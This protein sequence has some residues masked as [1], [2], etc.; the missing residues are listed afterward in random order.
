MALKNKDFIEIEYTGKVKD[1][2]I[3]FDTTN[4]KTAKE[5]NLSDQNTEFGPIVV[6]L[7]EGMLLKGLEDELIGKDP[8]SYNIDIEA[9]KGFGKKDPKLIK[10][11]PTAKFKKQQIQPVP[12]LQLNIDGMFGTIKT[13]SGGRTLVDF[14]HPLSGKELNYDIKVNKVVTDDNEKLK[15]FLKLNLNMKDMNVKIENNIGT[16]ISKEKIPDEI[17]GE[18]SKKVTELIPSIKGLK[19][20]ARSDQK[21]NKV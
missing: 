8:G 6:C 7:G 20:V 14:N 1:E 21:N 12:G 4:E 3:V 17:L 5:N 19:S 2:N 10:L 13:V 18:V 15:S 11:I 9:E 16:I